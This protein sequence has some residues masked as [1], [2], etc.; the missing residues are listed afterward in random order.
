MNEVRE[1]IIT[2]S[3]PFSMLMTRSSRRNAA[4]GFSPAFIA[5]TGSILSLPSR[6]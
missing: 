2:T 4:S 1:S 6:K 3:T 5:F